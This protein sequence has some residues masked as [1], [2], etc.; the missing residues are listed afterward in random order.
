[1]KKL[2]LITFLFF[3][4]HAKSQTTKPID[5][6]LG[7]KFGSSV[8][9]VTAALK[10]R[11]GK[12]SPGAS[13][14]LLSSSNIS[15]G[16]R[17]AESFFVMFIDDKAYGAYFVFRPELEP[18]LIDYYNSLVSDISDVYGKGKSHKTFKQPYEDGNGFEVQAITTGNADY[19]T[20]WTNEN[21]KIFATIESDGSVVLIY[22]E[23]NLTEKATKQGKEKEKA[24]F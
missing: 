12:I 20:I 1:M 8:A 21:N 19:E 24:D 15:L 23:G 22:S 16:S 17:K 3:A 14:T 2:L 7:I 10:N 4:F 9:E 13:P 11:G 6:F 18:Q 5:S